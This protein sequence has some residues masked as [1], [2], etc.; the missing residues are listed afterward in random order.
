MN[1]S[2]VI[3]HDDDNDGVADRSTIFAH[4]HNPLGFEFWNG[5]VIVTSQPDILFLRD[6]DGDDVADERYVLFQGTDSADTHHAANNLI[7]GPDGGIYWQSGVFMQHNHEHPWGPSLESG[8]SGMYRFDP[9]RY[10]I[11]FHAVNSP[12]PHGI[13][14]DDWG[15]H[16]ANDG[17]GGRSYQV[18]PDEKG[19][20]MRELLTKE[21]RP[22]TADEIV[23]STN[24]P[25]E[26]QGNSLVCQP[27]HKRRRQVDVAKT[28]DCAQVVQRHTQAG[29]VV[30]LHAQGVVVQPQ[31]GFWRGDVQGIEELHGLVCRGFVAQIEKSAA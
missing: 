1:D 2:L 14:F 5:G 6:N 16:Y 7:Y 15:Y 12:N 4:V 13:A 21:V 31:V 22:V 8:A 30:D 18:V 28:H 20:K 24:F 19:F 17:T 9:R 23:S 25:D 26:M 11:A 3:L 10:T 29:F 27:V